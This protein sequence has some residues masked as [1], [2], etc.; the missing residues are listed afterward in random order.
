MSVLPLQVQLS[1]MSSLGLGHG[2]VASVPRGSWHGLCSHS[3]QPDLFS[4]Q[5]TAE[6]T[7]EKTIA[8]EVRSRKLCLLTAAAAAMSLELTSNLHITR[9]I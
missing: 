5:C 1:L 3:T 4:H 8:E 6:G 7:G 2:D 9:V